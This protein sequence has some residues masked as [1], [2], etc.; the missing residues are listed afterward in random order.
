MLTK[1]MTTLSVHASDL[2][3]LISYFWSDA[4]HR[5]MHSAF[6]LLPTNKFITK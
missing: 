4:E 1:M 5:T 2:L 6:L 3:A